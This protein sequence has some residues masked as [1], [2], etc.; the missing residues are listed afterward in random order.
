MIARGTSGWQ[1]VLADLSLILF[2][3]TA[4]ALDMAESAAPLSD[5]SAQPD[6][7]FSARMEG[8]DLAIWLANY[9]ADPRETLRIVITY[10]AGNL[11]EA[12]LRATNAARIGTAAGHAP[13]IVLE[14]GAEA[15]TA[16]TFTFDR[17]QVLARNLH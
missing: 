10:R 17:P 4:T 7:V 15:D 14:Q 6:T 5:I 8:D 12:L 11:D 2:I 13:Q 3:T 1:I 16:A 9:D